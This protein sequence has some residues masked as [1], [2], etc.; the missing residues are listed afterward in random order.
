MDEKQLL[1]VYSN[2]GYITAISPAEKLELAKSW[3]VKSQNFMKISRKYHHQSR[4]LNNITPLM[5]R[6]GYGGLYDSFT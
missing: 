4:L 5:D 3:G 6:S 1:V 2:L